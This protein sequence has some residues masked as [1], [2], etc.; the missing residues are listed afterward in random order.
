MLLNM[1]SQITKKYEDLQNA[2]FN[3]ISDLR[4]NK[5]FS[6]RTIISQNV[7]KSFLYAEQPAPIT[8]L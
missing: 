1:S 2:L 4:H 8:I 3:L 6:V 5:V 7:L